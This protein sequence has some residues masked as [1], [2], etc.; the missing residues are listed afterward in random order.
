MKKLLLLLAVFVMTVISVIAES[1]HYDPHSK[2]RIS[3]NETSPT[4][5]SVAQDS[6]GITVSYSLGSVFFEESKVLNGRYSV[7]LQDFGHFIDGTSPDLPFR[8]DYFALPNGV[9]N[10]DVRMECN[11]SVL[12]PMRLLSSKILSPTLQ[13][14]NSEPDTEALGGIMASSDSIA[15]L[16]CIGWKGQEFMAGVEIIPVRYDFA[17]KNI[18]IYTSFEY[19]LFF[20]YSEYPVAGLADLELSVKLPYFS[21]SYLILS[22]KEFQP[23]MSEFVKWKRQC[24]FNVIETY[25]KN[26]THNKVKDSIADVYEKNPNLKYVLIVGDGSVVPG[27]PN[28]YDGWKNMGYG[29]RKYMTDFPYSCLDSDSIPDIYIGRIPSR[30]TIEAANT[31]SKIIMSQK[32]PTTNQR[33]YETAIHTGIFTVRTDEIQQTYEPFVYT[34]EQIHDYV[35]LCGINGI[36]NYSAPSYAD[37]KYWAARYG[38]GAQIPL[39]LQRPNFEWNGT[40]DAINENIQ[41]G[42]LFVLNCGHG[43]KNYW[44]CSAISN[45]TKYTNTAASTLSNSSVGLPL[46]FNM[47]CSTGYYGNDYSHDCDG[48][49]PK[50][51]LAQ[52]LLR[53]PEGGASAVFAASE[54]SCMGMNDAMSVGFINGIWPN[55]GFNFLVDT[56]HSYYGTPDVEESCPILG[57]ILETGR[58]FQKAHYGMYNEQAKYN[59]RIYHLFGDPSMWVNTELPT[60][61]SG[62]KISVVPKFDIKDYLN[63]DLPIDANQNNE[64]YKPQLKDVRVEVEYVPDCRISIIDANGRLVAF[65]GKKGEL[66][67]VMSPLTVT[68]TAPNKIPYEYTYIMVGEEI[69]PELQIWRISPN[70]TKDGKITVEIRDNSGDIDGLSFFEEILLL[71][72]SAEGNFEKFVTLPK[73]ENAISVSCDGLK[74]GVHLLLV[75]GDGQVFDSKRF[76]VL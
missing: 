33:Y 60:K 62:V 53:N 54:Y 52:A 34:S 25:D 57:K 6:T 68:I 27:V 19:R 45:N 63:E 67:G 20:E 71:V 37:P 1:F 31:L 13:T 5:V 9:S 47:S 36:R 76:V 72:Y 23:S 26:W 2:M 41:K 30:N 59:E 65:R 11:D 48:T 49:L 40:A 69:H 8:V 17:K 70:P 44:V 64:K 22:S 58:A 66:N 10:V 24:G 56:N 46:F 29:V 3:A 55:P 32:T 28:S 38:N 35:S 61:F 21:Q 39:Y 43:S 42:A 15:K 75:A 12:L 18:I 51:G 74:S 16:H 7:R 50:E 14:E 4:S 73:K